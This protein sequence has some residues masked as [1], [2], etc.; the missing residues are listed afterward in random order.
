MGVCVNALCEKL[1]AIIQAFV[2]LHTHLIYNSNI[3]YSKVWM[4]GTMYLQ[5]D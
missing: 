1:L 2:K 5:I 4:D 3:S